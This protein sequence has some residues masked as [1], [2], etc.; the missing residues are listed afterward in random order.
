M[1]KKLVATASSVAEAREKWQAANTLLGTNNF[2][3]RLSGMWCDPKGNNVWN[4]TVTHMKVAKITTSYVILA[5]STSY[6]I[7]KVKPDSEASEWQ[8]PEVRF[9]A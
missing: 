1:L 9:Y 3:V 5:D 2:E 8:K 4:I 7:V 6:G